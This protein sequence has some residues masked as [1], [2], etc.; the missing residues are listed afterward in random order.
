MN[1]PV[2]TAL[3]CHAPLVIPQIAGGL[4]PS[5]ALSTKAMQSAAQ[6]LCAPSPELLVVV[7][8]HTPRLRNDFLLA[9]NETLTGD[10]AD[11]GKADMRLTFSG[12]PRA[13]KRLARKAEE[14][15]E[16]AASGLLRTL[17]HGALVPLFF[18]HEAGTSAPVVVIALPMHVEVED[19]RQFGRWLAENLE[20]KWALVASGDM[21]HRLKPGAPAGYHPRASEFD[22]TVTE[23][24][25]AGKI[26]DALA[27]STTLR[28]LA[29]EDALDS[30][31]VACGALG[32]RIAPADRASYE[33][34]F[35]VGYLISE[36]ATHV[37]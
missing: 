34:P 31:A 2:S 22:Q 28:D 17:D 5:A 1:H 30:L 9:A 27:I 37:A 11:F 23:A 3:M 24:V 33:A 8:P 4:A 10:F 26:D 16:G 14:T 6:A 13:V 15:S 32:G 29:A 20:E 18:L 35:G 21:S 19:C 12:A 7:S 36:L 25:R